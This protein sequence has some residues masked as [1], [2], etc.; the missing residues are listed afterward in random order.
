M[1]NI[2]EV[3]EKAGVSPATV[4]RAFTTPGLISVST[5]QRVFEA[6]RVLDYNPTRSR[7]PRQPSRERK[8]ATNSASASQAPAVRDAIGFQFFAA[9]ASPDDTLAHNTFYATLL[10]GAQS[11]AAALGLHLLIH[12][13][14]RHTLSQEMPRMIEERVIGGMLLVG[15]ADPQIVSAFSTYV[16]NIVLV[17]N[18]DPADAFESVVSDGFGGAYRATRYLIDLGHRHLCF[19]MGEADTPSFQD[20]LRGFWCAQLDAGITPIPENIV[21]G[22]EEMEG[23]LAQLAS[24]LQ[25]LSAT[26]PTAVLAAN[27]EHAFQVLRVCRDL[28]LHVPTDLSIVG[29]DDT[30]FS[31]HSDPPLTTVQVDKEYMGR[32]AVRRLYA[33]MNRAASLL[34]EEN[35]PAVTSQVGVTLI[36]RSSCAAPAVRV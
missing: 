1:A 12:T 34:T 19:L 35:Q 33:R 13:T 11:E 32:L 9:T 31:C 16:D 21:Y 18:R 7:S 27:D 3:A 26:R 23:R 10:S 14:D 30:V 24:L 25:Q 20:R 6:A 2:R 4:S 22:H 36:K 15:T 17:D 29:F 5:Q 28:G 8:N